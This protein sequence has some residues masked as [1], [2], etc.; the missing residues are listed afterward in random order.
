MSNNEVVK[1][2]LMSAASEF[3]A[4]REKLARAEMQYKRAIGVSPDSIIH[5]VDKGVVLTY[6]ATRTITTDC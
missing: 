4:A 3:E 1:Q 2:A 5:A 6:V